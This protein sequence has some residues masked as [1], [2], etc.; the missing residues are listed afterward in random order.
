MTRSPNNNYF[1]LLGECQS[2]L[3]RSGCTSCPIERRHLLSLITSDSSTFHVNRDLPNVSPLYR[4]GPISTGILTITVRHSL[5]SAR[6]SNPPTAC[7][8]VSLP[9]GR[10]YWVPTFRIIDPISHLGESSTP[11]VQQSRAGSYKT[12][13]LTTCAS[14]RKHS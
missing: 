3:I 2:R 7:L 14:T 6:Q 10:R 13:I 9:R 8:T 5:L 11:V 1:T 4:A 12:C